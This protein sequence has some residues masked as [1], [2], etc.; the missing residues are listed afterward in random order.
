MVRLLRDFHEHKDGKV[1]KRK[2]GEWV[3]VS[4]ETAD[5]LAQATIKRRART[6]EL[7]KRISVTP[8]SK[9]K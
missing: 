4:R 3:D 9:R 6:R 8:E 7:A 1:T 5:F 2:A